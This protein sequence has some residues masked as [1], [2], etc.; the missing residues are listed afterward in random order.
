VHEHLFRAIADVL[1]AAVTPAAGP[2]PEPNVA[3]EAPPDDGAGV[4]PPGR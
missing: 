2:A 4:A 3:G 1:G